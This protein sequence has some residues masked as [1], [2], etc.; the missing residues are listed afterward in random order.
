MKF[1]TR[2]TSSSLPLCP[3]SLLFYC[4]TITLDSPS[5]TLFPFPLLAFGFNGLKC[6]H[7][8][9]VMTKDKGKKGIWGRDSRFAESNKKQMMACNGLKGTTTELRSQIIHHTLGAD[10]QLEHRIAHSK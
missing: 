8:F 3:K 9:A 2:Y 10:V 1:K 6:L 4:A 5:P 7:G